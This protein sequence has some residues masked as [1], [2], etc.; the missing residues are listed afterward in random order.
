MGRRS[1]GRVRWEQGRGRGR[2]LHIGQQRVIPHE[3]DFSECAAYLHGTY[4]SEPVFESPVVW[5]HHAK[6]RDKEREVER[7]Q[8]GG[9]GMREVSVKVTCRGGNT[10][11]LVVTIVNDSPTKQRK[12]T[13]KAKREQKYQTP[14]P[15][16]GGEACSK[17]CEGAT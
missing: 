7:S 12:R 8:K 3:D 13:S 10:R 15:G 9:L 16:C 4:A 11:D 2:Q 6:M 14:L 1:G 5:S 17:R